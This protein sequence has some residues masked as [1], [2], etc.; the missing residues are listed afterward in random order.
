VERQQQELMRLK[1]PQS[2]RQRREATN[3]LLRKVQ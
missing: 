1:A 2:L 3:R